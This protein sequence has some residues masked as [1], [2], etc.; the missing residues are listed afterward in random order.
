SAH[1][2]QHA[3]TRRLILARRSYAA[4]R[5]DNIHFEADDFVHEHVVRLSR[6][7]EDG[8]TVLA[9]LNFSGEPRRVSLYLPH[10][11][12]WHD[13]VGEHTFHLSAGTHHF[14]L[15]AWHGLLLVPLSARQ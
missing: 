9:A 12:I 3:L 1:Q 2:E 7:D 15:A 6:W 11:G 8:T 14:D 5:S 10:S 4:L 13:V